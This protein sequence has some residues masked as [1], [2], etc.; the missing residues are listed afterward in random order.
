[1]LLAQSGGGT[2]YHPHPQTLFLQL[3]AGE[4][5]SRGPAGRHAG[6]AHPHPCVPHAGHG[7][8]RR[9]VQ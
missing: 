5:N 3:H 4:P 2:F 6:S 8:A 9:L 7:G 1:M